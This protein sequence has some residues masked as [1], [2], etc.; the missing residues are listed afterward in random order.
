MAGSGQQCKGREYWS[1]IMNDQG[2]RFIR[3]HLIKRVPRRKSTWMWGWRKYSGREK[4]NV[5]ALKKGEL[6]IFIQTARRSV[7][8]RRQNSEK[9]NGTRTG[10]GNLGWGWEEVDHEESWRSLDIRLF[11]CYCVFMF[12]C[13]SLK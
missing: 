8:Q 13:I 2:K 3:C 10:R 11:E 4:G 12:N 9:V 1:F 6:S 5:K 7:S